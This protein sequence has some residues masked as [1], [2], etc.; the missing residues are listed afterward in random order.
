MKKAIG[1][2]GILFT[3]AV[4]TGCVG[5]KKYTMHSIPADSFG[6]KV[7]SREALLAEG[8][9]MGNSASRQEASLAE[10]I[11]A[12]NNSAVQEF[13]K[14]E[15]L[16]VKD[17]KIDEETLATLKETKELV[18]KDLQTSEA[19]LAILKNFETLSKLQGTGE[20]TLFFAQDAAAITRGS[21]NHQRLVHFMDYLATRSLG[22]KVKFLVVGS[23]SEI[24]NSKHNLKLSEKRAKAPVELIDTYLMNVPHEILKVYGVGDSLSP[25]DVKV[26]R[27]FQHVRVIAVYDESQAPPLPE[28][29]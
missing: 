7:E 12:T 4:L 22:R 1:L 20:I 5:T 21:E 10:M 25:K 17:L 26:S 29:K 3:C 2:V 6:D 27:K 13:A 14:V 23:A 11:V 24:G 18:A 19:A 8:H 9:F 15:T 28:K 16:E